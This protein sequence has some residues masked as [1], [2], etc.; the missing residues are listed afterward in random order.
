M[1]QL[2]QQR[3][4]VAKLIRCNRYHGVGCTENIMLIGDAA[5]STGGTLGQGA[6]SALLDVVALDKA[7]DK[8]RGDISS[9]LKMYSEAQVKEGL[10]L[11]T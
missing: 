11:W 2:A 4:S 3:P 1:N 10:A 9:A 8:S 6:N 7:L 5:H